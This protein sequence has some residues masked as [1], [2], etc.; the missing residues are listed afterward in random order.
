MVFGFEKQI[1]I[2]TGDKK[3]LG[4]KKDK[5]DRRDF[6]GSGMT[7]KPKI[8]LGIYASTIKNQGVMNSCSGHAAILVFEMERKIRHGKHWWIDGSEQHNYYYSRKLNGLFPK[9]VGSYL[10][11]ACKVMH[12]IGVCP[13]KLMPY[14]DYL[15]NYKPGLFTNSFANFWK[16]KK[17]IRQTS[18]NTIK[19]SLY[20]K[21]P[22]MLG[23][24]VWKEFLTL[25]EKDVPLPD[26][27]KKSLGGHAITIIGYDDRQKAFHIQNSWRTTWG[28]FGRAWLPYK[29]L[30]MVPWWDAWS[31]RI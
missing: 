22:V 20:H 31:I 9:D 17:Y 13:E 12:K 28:K 4:V 24:P 27:N 18:I 30:E 5:K 7:D 29:Y 1:R 19:N 26:T 10:R 14:I 23:V 21:H 11:D 16:I 8:D 6:L 25:R 2:I 3:R 15:P